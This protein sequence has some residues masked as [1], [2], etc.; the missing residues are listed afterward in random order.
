V[1]S[2]DRHADGKP[3][4]V[5]TFD[6]EDWNQLVHRRLGVE[7]WD[8]P[9]PSFERQMQAVFTLLAEL[10]AGATF[11]L[12]ALTA[13]NYPHLIEEIVDRGYEVA[14][15]GYEH[16]RVYRQT[17]HEFQHDLER[18]SKLIERLTGRRPRG[19]RAP[20]FSINRQTPW[21]YDVLAELGF[22]YDS[23]AFDSPRVPHRIQSVP[24]HPY[25]LELG[26]GKT[27]WEFP[28]AVRRIRT[29]SLPLGGGSYWRL[30][31]KGI[32]LSALDATRRENSHPLLYFHP[33]E[34]GPEPLRA[35]LPPSPSAEQRLF[36][37]YKSSWRN[38]GRKRVASLIREVGQHYS[39]KSC[40]EAHDEIVRNYRACS[41][42]LSKEG[43]L[44]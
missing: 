6:V 43:V 13:K 35:V 28:I 20:A 36:A 37:T 16:E 25:R 41:R 3:S 29:R 18:S 21:A 34:F 24:P 19:Y 9:Y 2:R 44:V 38:T 15:H 42:T 14:C 39:L 17:R 1:P 26:D 11:F 40:E 10:R 12:L 5:L 8:E 33:Y 23:S 27:L 4:F 22:G 7:R 32:L 31:P 30:L